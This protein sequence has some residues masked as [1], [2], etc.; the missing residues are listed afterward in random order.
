MALSDNSRARRNILERIRSA[1]GRTGKVSEAEQASIAGYLARHP[2]GPQPK[3]YADL[4]ERFCAKAADNSSSVAVVDGWAAATSA[5]ASFLT[6]HALAPRAV[7]SATLAPLDWVGVG[8][9]VEVRTPVDA[10]L[11]GI[12]R[13]FCAIA[14]TGT[15]TFLSEPETPPTIN[16][17]PETH[18]ALLARSRIVST[19]EEAFD[20]IRA[21]RGQLPRATNFI[22]GPS[23]TGDIEQTIVLGA[24]GPRIV[25]IVVVRSA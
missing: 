17:L 5:V 16:L 4:L 13:A 8:L 2:R 7:L 10:D 12:S 14:E 6:A 15:L 21:E 3:P 1:Q 25:H 18:I 20:L 19:M 24:H 11:V 23:R 9:S 22:S